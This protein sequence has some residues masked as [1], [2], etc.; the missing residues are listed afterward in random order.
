ME[1][2]DERRVAALGMVLREVLE[3]E[4]L[5]LLDLIYKILAYDKIDGRVD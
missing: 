4:N 2:D 1:N 3:C 5:E